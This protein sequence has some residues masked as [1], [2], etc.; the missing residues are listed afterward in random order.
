M[1]I[2]ILAIGEGWLNVIQSLEQT[3]RTLGLKFGGNANGNT[4]SRN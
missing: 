3:N 2:A 1:A 4:S